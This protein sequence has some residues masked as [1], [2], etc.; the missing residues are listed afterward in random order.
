MSISFYLSRPTGWHT[1]QAVLVGVCLFYF[2]AIF[3]N[4]IRD[5]SLIW[6]ECSCQI[7]RT[8]K[9]PDTEFSVVSELGLLTSI[10]MNLPNHMRD[11]SC[12][13]KL[14]S[15]KAYR[16]LQSWSISWI[17]PHEMLS[18]SHHARL[19]KWPDCMSQ[20]YCFRLLSFGVIRYS[21]R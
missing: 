18:Q 5:G 15:V 10:R 19:F 8:L 20:A 9:E 14:H 1:P 13:W 4:K 12:I 3:Q 21:S 17:Q 11:P 2:V 6:R 7:V 16:W